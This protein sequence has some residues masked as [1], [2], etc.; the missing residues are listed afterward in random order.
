MNGYT[1]M[2]MAT[3]IAALVTGAGCYIKL[4]AEVVTKAE[5]GH[6]IRTESPYYAEQKMI[7]NTLDTLTA[8]VKDLQQ[9]QREFD[10]RQAEILARLNLVLIEGK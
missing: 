2:V 4:A 3:L 8:S 1:K 5:V 10:R 6:L 7:M 9:Q